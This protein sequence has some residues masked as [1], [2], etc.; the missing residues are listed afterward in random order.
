MGDPL[1]DE[2]SVKPGSPEVMHSRN[3][4]YK[5][6]L[7]SDAQPVQITHHAGGN[8]YYPSLSSDGKVIVY[9][10]DFGLWK[11]DVAS[12]KS[13]EVKIDIT[14]ENK[15]NDSEPITIENEADGFDLSPSGKRAVISARNQIFTIAT[16][17]G[18]ISAIA[19]DMGALAQRIARLVARRQAHC[20]YFG[21]HGPRGS[22]SRR[23]GRQE[24]EKDH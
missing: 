20:L 7:K 22:L 18:D 13:T 10:A 3:N 15:D 2:K 16:D 9:E 1:P 8:V 19:N 4:I 17:R 14:T 11:L 23:P 24:S 6:W 12:G 5:I 21:P